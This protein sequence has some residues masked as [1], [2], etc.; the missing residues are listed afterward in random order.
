MERTERTSAEHLTQLSIARPVYHRMIEHLRRWLPDEGCG[1]L[2]GKKGLVSQ[3]YPGTN[4]EYSP[5][6]YSM[7]PSEII[8]ALRDVDQRELDVMAIFHS[9]PTTQAYP[10]QSDRDLLYDPDV[11]VVI[12]SF[13]EN[14]AVAR[15]FDLKD[16]IT[17]L[18]I[19]VAEA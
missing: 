5:T 4:T 3:I 14:E 11:I 16:E 2:A 9:H 15:A 17:E 1:I 6:R 18:P 10:S 12:V 8:R 13:A 7:D 19:V